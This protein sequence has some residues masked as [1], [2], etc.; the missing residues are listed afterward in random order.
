MPNNW[1][2]TT[3]ER[4]RADQPRSIAFIESNTTGTGSELINRAVNRGL[5]TIVLVRDFEKYAFLKDSTAEICVTETKDPDAVL[6]TLSSRSLRAVCTTSDP[7]TEVS[8]KVA[9]ALGCFGP[10]PA[11]CGRC[12]DKGIQLEILERAGVRVPPTHIIAKGSPAPRYVPQE[13]PWILK[14]CRGSGSIDV[15]VLESSADIEGFLMSC[16]DLGKDRWLLQRFIEGPEFSVELAVDKHG[17]SCLGVVE[18]R[19]G[20]PPARVEV[21]HLFP[22]K[23]SSQLREQLIQTAITA[24]N[25]LGFDFGFV[26]VEL[27]AN[28]DGLNLI[29]VNPRMGG[30]GLPFMIT[31]ATGRDMLE[32]WLT[33]HLT[34]RRP[35]GMCAPVLQSAAIAFRSAENEGFLRDIHSPAERVEQIIRVEILRKQGQDIRLNGD[36]RDRIISAIATSDIDAASA[37]D[38]AK[39]HLEKFDLE[40]ADC[41]SDE[42]SS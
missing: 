41:S 7:F 18:K 36:F 19:I 8:A 17:I 42:T 23:I 35:D 11:A 15:R 38:I 16:S 20:D 10:N 6:Q 31:A 34:G 9:E 4:E 39:F 33:L 5:S 22:P 3:R 28:A 27:I 24:T 13:G 29:E 14:P 21:A 26:H 1:T 30:G 40:F 32:D 25:A 2:H 12:L 37:L